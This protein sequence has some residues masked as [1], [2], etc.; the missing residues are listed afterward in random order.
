MQDTQEAYPKIKQIERFADAMTHGI[1]LGLS[2]I[3]L[4]ILILKAA[5]MKDTW[6]FISFSIY[7]ITLVSAYL[8]STFYHLYIFY[9]QHPNKHFKR[10][11]L[12]YDHCSIFYLIAGSYTPILLL[13]MRESLGM[14]Y[15]ISIW[16]LAFL[17]VLY[18]IYFLGKFKRFS[19]F[20][21]ITMGWCILLSFKELV[22]SL[23]HNLIVTLLIGGL[24]YTSGVVFYQKKS[25]PFNHAIWHI[26]V[27]IGS[28]VHFCGIIFFVN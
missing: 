3:A 12:L 2:M 11:L 22:N 1:G 4:I 14:I 26:F 10:F 8:S 27:L 21:Y 23:P 24:F 17:G 9:H 25:V 28:I 13:F 15:F 18:K 19:L 16:G 6:V 5:L 20:M 7:G